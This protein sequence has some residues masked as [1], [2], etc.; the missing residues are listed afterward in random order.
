M[1]VIITGGTGLIG[2]PL[3]ASLA[4]DGNEVVLLSRSPERQ[5]RL[6]RGVRAERWDGRSAEGWGPLA[7]G[8]GAIINLAGENLSARPWSREQK[9]KILDSRVNAGQ[10]V[11]QA[12]EA[13]VQKPEV[14]VQA[15]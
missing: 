15:S 1:R 4:A 5:V 6:P 2:R 13:A 8:A 12:V 14:V 9:R 3:A 11:V 10:A 7:E